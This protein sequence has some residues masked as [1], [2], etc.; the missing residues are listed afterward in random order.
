MKNPSKKFIVAAAVAGLLAGITLPS[1]HSADK[2]DP[3]GQEAPGKMTPKAH[4]CAGKND[5]KGLG[6]CKTAKND[7]KFLNE[8]KGKGGCKLTQ[9]D[10]DKKFGKKKS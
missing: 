10:I 7:C 8:C 3:A 9:K 6:G 5:C 4:D 1:A 2:K